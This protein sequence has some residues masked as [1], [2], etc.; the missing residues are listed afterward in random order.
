MESHSP[1]EILSRLERSGLRGRGGGWYPAAW[2]WRAVR[3]EGERPVLVANGAEGEPGSIKD[4]YVMLR[5][6]GDVVAGLGMAA[7]ALRATEAIVYVKGAFAE[8]A[9]RL[10]RTLSESRPERLAVRVHRGEDSYI[11]GEETVLLESLE[12]RRAWPRPKPP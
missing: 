11:A 7:Q 2:K 8:P 9:A 6:P 12:G 1:D 5:R 4:R 10:E 3:A